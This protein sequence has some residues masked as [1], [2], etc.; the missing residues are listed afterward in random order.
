M[1]AHRGIKTGTLMRDARRLCPAVIPVQANHRLYTVKLPG[2]Q[3]QLR[4]AG[5][6][7]AGELAAGGSARSQESRG[8]ATSR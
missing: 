5:E 7:G 3:A 1:L 8:R 4:I 2:G 6:I